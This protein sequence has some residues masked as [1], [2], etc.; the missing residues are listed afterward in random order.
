MI[1]TRT[2]YFDV[3]VTPTADRRTAILVVA[4]E[5]DLGSA[6]ELW[7]HLARLLGGRAGP[8][9]VVLDGRALDFLDSS[10]LRVL[11]RAAKLAQGTGTALRIVAPNPVV[12]RVLELSGA[13]RALDLRSSLSEALA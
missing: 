10:G 8:E 6:E 1:M 13:A 9:V 7:P 11:L 12:A 2:K 4:G 3:T 5:L